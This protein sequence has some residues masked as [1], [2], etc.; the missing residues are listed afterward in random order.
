M[1][2]CWVV[3]GRHGFV[4]SRQ[5]FDFRHVAYKKVLADFSLSDHI[6]LFCANVLYVVI[7]LIYL[8]CLFNLFVQPIF[9]TNLFSIFI[10]PINIAYLFIPSA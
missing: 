7:W 10:Q 5:A 1:Y 3:V 9:S 2:W 6:S 8:A 4:L